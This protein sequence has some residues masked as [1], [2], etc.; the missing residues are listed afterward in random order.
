M[1]RRV[2]YD[3]TRKRWTTC[4]APPP[5][6]PRP[7]MPPL[8][9]RRRRHQPARALRHDDHP[10]RVRRTI[11]SASRSRA[12]PRRR[13]RA[14]SPPTRAGCA[15]RTGARPSPRASPARRRS[16]A[17]RAPT[18]PAPP[19]ASP[20]SRDA[21]PLQVAARPTTTLRPAYGASSSYSSA[22]RAASPSRPQTSASSVIAISHCASRGSVPKP[23]CASA[24]N[25]A[26]A[27][28]SRPSSSCSSAS[29]QRHAG[30]AGY[31]AM[32][33]R[34]ASSTSASRPCSRRMLYIDWANTWTAF[35]AWPRCPIASVSCASRSASSKS[36]VELRLRAAEHRRPPL[37]QRPVQRRG[38]A[39]GGGDLDVG[40]GHVAQLE[41]VDDGPA[42]ALQ[43][44]L[45]IADRLGQPAQLGRDRQPLL[46]RLGPPERVVAGVQAG[47][48]RERVAEPARERD[49]L[50]GERQ[51]PVGSPA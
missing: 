17:R 21:E 39:R 28:S 46:H 16:G 18:R 25:S 14:P 42:G 4:T 29:E 33:P 24:S 3:A 50:G 43:L 5:L 45:G 9:L 6:D 15:P 26:R 35:S 22:A 7:S 10:E 19:P 48:E 44:E 36:P 23:A 27:S 12:A 41:Q 34:T 40:A 11:A 13:A 8:T 2:A 32:K 1:R 31:M 49:R 47:R 20:S 37:V 38:E 30:T 51:P